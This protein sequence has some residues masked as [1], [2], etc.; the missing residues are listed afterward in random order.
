MLEHFKM[1]EYKTNVIVFLSYDGKC[2]TLPII[3]HSKPRSKYDTNGPGRSCPEI[4]EPNGRGLA[5]STFKT[6][7]N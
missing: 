5:L 1:F 3:E 7:I 6:D 2:D 4:L